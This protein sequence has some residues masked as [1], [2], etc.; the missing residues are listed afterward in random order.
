MKSYPHSHS[1]QSSRSPP[2]T[3]AFSSGSGSGSQ[4][5]SPGVDMV[6]PRELGV[7]VHNN[8]GGGN[9]DSVPSD[10]MRRGL[11]PMQL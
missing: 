6:D 9:G 3:S 1:A 8:D 10:S 2:P 5:G 7:L 4:P 11:D